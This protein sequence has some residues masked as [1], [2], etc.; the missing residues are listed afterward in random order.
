MVSTLFTTR[1]SD[2]S[3]LTELG[4]SSPPY[5]L[6]N[7]ALHVGDSKDDVFAN[8]A[9]LSQGTATPIF[10]NQI[11]G[12]GI[13]V[14]DGI[15]QT[16]P[17]AD[18]LIT[19]EPGIA[20][21]VL[22]A[23]CIPLLLWDSKI[24]LVAAVHVGRRGLMNNITGKVVERMEAMGARRI[25]ASLGPSICGTCYEVGEDVFT[26]VVNQFPLAKS[27]TRDGKYALDLSAGLVGVLSEC[28]IA[29]EVS[30]QCTAE[31]PDLFSYRRD[32]VCGRQAG[33]IWI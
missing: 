26:E 4:V 5:D 16:E 19:Q 31:I 15:S 25:L 27:Q 14:I 10:M 9:L 33:V 8:R 29:S 17:T 13:V 32:G 7:L 3:G 20:L 28:G 6:F 2:G 18:A 22:V 12:D 24:D 30:Q 21:C 1:S 23:D 11:H